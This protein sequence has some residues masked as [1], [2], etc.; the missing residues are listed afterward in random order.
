M[1]LS[2]F[3][4]INN[5]KP[6]VTVKPDPETTHGGGDRYRKS[7]VTVFTAVCNIMMM[8]IIFYLIQNVYYRVKP[9]R[10]KMLGRK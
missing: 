10:K 2:L 1:T 9:F 7:G 3:A 5:R 4:C 6:I 8:M